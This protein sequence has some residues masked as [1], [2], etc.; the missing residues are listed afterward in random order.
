MLMTIF[1]VLL[2]LWLTGHGWFDTLGGASHLLPDY[3]AGGNPGSRDSGAQP[4]LAQHGAWSSATRVP[5][6]RPP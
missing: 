5:F 3:R 1:V 4:G 2:I 6:R